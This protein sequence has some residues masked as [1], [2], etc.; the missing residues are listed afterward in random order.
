MKTITIK[1]LKFIGKII[2][3]LLKLIFVLPLIAFC[4]GITYD[5]NTFEK[6]LKKL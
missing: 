3:K 4:F 1:I 6:E 2:L 5:Y